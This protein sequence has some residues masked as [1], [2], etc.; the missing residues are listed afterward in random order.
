MATGKRLYTLGDPTDWVYCVSWSPDKKHL[1]AAGVD[2]S[3]RVWV[4]DKEG[5]KL[6]HAV[7]A[8]EKPVWRLAYSSDGAT[9]FTAGED[10]IIKSWDAAKMMEK[11]VF[12]AQPDAVLDFAVGPGGKQLAV[13]RF[14]G[15]LVLLDAATGKAT[16][17][18]LP[19]RP[20]TPKAAKITPMG[21][22]RG[23]TTRLVVTG[24][25]LD[26]L[27]RVTVSSGDVTVKIDAATQSSEEVTLEVAV[28]PMAAIGAVQLTFEGD[29]GKPAGSLSEF[30]RI[31][32][33]AADVDPFLVSRPLDERDRP[34][35]GHAHEELR[36]L[37]VA[38]RLVSSDVEHIT[39]AHVR[40]A[41][42]QER[43]RGIVDVDEIAQL[44]S[45][46]EDLDL[47]TLERQSDEPADESLAV[48]FD[49]LPRPVDVRQAQR[50]GAHVEH[51]VESR[52]CFATALF[53]PLMSAGRTRCFSSTG[54]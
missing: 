9:L 13:A 27:K 12:N 43:V 20:V 10:R 47:T 42:P 44:R 14:D 49:Q 41:G 54:R 26:Q 45:V 36:E 48:V 38:D 32:V 21:T 17:Q 7:F 51:V 46:A 16:N 3:V 23:Q 35:A 39:I 30:R 8:H 1:A 6:V 5:G 24:A 18:P 2:K 22:V 50:A 34:A 28:K 52:W 37:T 31:G 25:N 19:A 15:A 40:G 4:A 11:K 29:A 33:E 53:T